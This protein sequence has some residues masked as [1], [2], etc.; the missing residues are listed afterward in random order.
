M[1]IEKL[2]EDVSIKIITSHNTSHL[3]TSAQ[4]SMCLSLMLMHATCCAVS[5]S[6]PMEDV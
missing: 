5:N 2:V 4:L 1:H 6:S 3:H